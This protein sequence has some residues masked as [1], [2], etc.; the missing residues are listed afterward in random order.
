MFRF[1][2]GV[3]EEFQIKLAVPSVQLS[4]LGDV[5]AYIERVIAGEGVPA[6]TAASLVPSVR[7]S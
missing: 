7:A 1:T 4:T 2:L 5:V 6:I 3:E